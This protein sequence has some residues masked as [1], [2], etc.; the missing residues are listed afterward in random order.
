MTKTTLDVQDTSEKN[1]MEENICKPCQ[2]VWLFVAHKYQHK[3]VIT[4]KKI[5]FKM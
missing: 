1:K 4:N 2:I 3:I 5:Q